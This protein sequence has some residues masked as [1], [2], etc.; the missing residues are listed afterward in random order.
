LGPVWSSG[1]P[2]WIWC[3]DC[4][5]DGLDDQ[6]LILS[7]EEDPARD[8]LVVLF[9]NGTAASVTVTVTPA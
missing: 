9:G 6:L 7:H 8:L 1:R 3:G 5:A 2:W 4:D